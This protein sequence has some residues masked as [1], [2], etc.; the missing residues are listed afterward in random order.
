MSSITWQHVV[1]GGQIMDHIWQAVA[2]EAGRTALGV[3]G[4]VGVGNV[5]VM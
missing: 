5:W 1:V 3:G 2:C 4:Q